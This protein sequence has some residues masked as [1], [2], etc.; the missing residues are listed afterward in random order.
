M[1]ISLSSVSLFAISSKFDPNPSDD[2]MVD[3]WAS[4]PDTN[5]SQEGIV[6]SSN[7]DS[8]SL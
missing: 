2:G 3:A 8:S 4:S 1:V 5:S 7:S 6:G